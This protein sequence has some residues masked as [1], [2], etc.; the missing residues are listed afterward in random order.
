MR[1]LRNP[2]PSPRSSRL[3]DRVAVSLAI[4]IAHAR[5]L[6]RA[7]F[8][9]PLRYP[10]TARW[11]TTPNIFT[12]QY[13]MT[14]GPTPLPPRVSQ[15]MAEPILYHRAPAFVEV[16]ARVP[17]AAA[18]VF[19]TANQVLCFAASGTGA[20]ESAVA[21]LI[22][23]GEPRCR[24]LLRQVRRAL[25]RALRR[26]RRR[27]HATSRSS[28]ASGSTPSASTRA[29]SGWTASRRAVFV[30]QSETSTGVVNDV[31]RPE[32]G[33]PRAR[34][35]ALRRRD[36]GPRRR[37]PAPGRVGGGRRRRRLAEVADVPARPRLR[38]G[39]RAR[40]W[41]S[42][43]SAPAAAT[44]STGRG[45]PTGQAQEPPNSA[46]TPAVTLFW[47]LDVALGM[48]FEE[49]LGA[50][51]ARHAVLARAARAGIEALGL[52]RFGPDDPDA[53][54]VTAAR[55]PDD[56]R[57]RQGAEADA[58]PLRRH[59]RRRPGPPEGQDRP[60]R[61]LRLLRRLRHRD[62]A[63]RARDGA[64]RPRL[65]RSS[66][67]P[68]SRRPSASSPRPARSPRAGRACTMAARA[69][70][71][72][73]GAA[74]PGQGEDR[75]RRGRAAARATSTSSS[76]STGTTASSSER[77][78]EFDAILIRSATKLTAELIERADAPAG[79]RPRRHRG[80]QRRH[81][82]RDQARDHRRQ[83]ARV[84]LGRRRRAHAGAGAGAVPQR[85]AGARLA[86]RRRVGALALRRQRALRQDA[87]RDRLRPHRPARRQAA[88]RPSTWRSS[89]STSSSPPSASA[90]SASRASRPARSSTGAPT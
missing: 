50:V 15:V 61:P 85:P 10:Q 34:R 53:N 84:E 63:D 81:R 54:V 18:E 14:A 39:L 35:R 74:G 49:G 28:G 31:R 48:I 80:R 9:A 7:H 40:R 29:L 45:Q 22:G 38:L 64:A 89:A 36:L 69:H 65:R 71:H 79:D 24:R 68:A 88:P 77:I 59:R 6:C 27:D 87:R 57:R 47:A 83:R 73:P 62:R 56:D 8:R 86:G 4:A 33:R 70:A 26:L 16:Y 30:T 78:G 25:G 2:E 51:F 55:L 72:R 3:A 32:R 75:R 19:Q 67:A 11:P 66:P 13:L 44:T 82:G 42:P 1:I 21:N 37:R 17:R 12:K 46:F 23:P 90:S 20:M 60:H 76:G 5:I 43:P 58:R 41:R 52:E